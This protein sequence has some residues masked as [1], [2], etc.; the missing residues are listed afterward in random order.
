M[1]PGETIRAGANPVCDCGVAFTFEVLESPAG[2]YVGTRCHNP[3]CDDCGI[4]YTRESHY[5]PTEAAAQYALN[6]GAVAWRT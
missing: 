4:P 5:Y 3:G 1:L 6:T 2:Y